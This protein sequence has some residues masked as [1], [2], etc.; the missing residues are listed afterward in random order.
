MGKRTRNWKRKGIFMH[1]QSC[2]GGNG[3][4]PVVSAGYHLH[5]FCKARLAIRG[6]DEDE[7]EGRTLPSFKYIGGQRL[8]NK[9][10]A[11]LFAP[12]VKVPKRPSL[13]SV[14]EPADPSPGGSLRSEY[15]PQRNAGQSSSGGWCT[16]PCL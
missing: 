2:I 6:V 3:S 12:S 11:S 15:K 5:Y 13:V 8:F 16:E 9:Y 4:H 10:K 1:G 14:A 7:E